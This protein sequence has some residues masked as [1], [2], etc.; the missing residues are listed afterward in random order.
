MVAA[1]F[2]AEVSIGKKV[3]YK[4]VVPPPNCD[5][6]YELVAVQFA[7]LPAVAL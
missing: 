3:L 1:S 2:I 5:N 6:A 7:L 4:R